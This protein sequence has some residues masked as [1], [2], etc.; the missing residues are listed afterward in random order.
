MPRRDRHT[1]WSFWLSFSSVAPQKATT[2]FGQVNRT[3]VESI[4]DVLVNF[5]TASSFSICASVQTTRGDNY[6]RRHD[7]HRHRPQS[8][9]SWIGATFHV[10]V[11][12]VPVLGT[13][14][15]FVP[16]IENSFSKSVSRFIIFV[17]RTYVP[18]TLVT[19]A[20]PQ[21]QVEPCGLASSNPSSPW[22]PPDC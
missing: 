3:L 11:S 1:A 12:C 19:V 20:Q 9:E 22:H 21:P 17:P 8:Q 16:T 6:K 14:I 13:W 2:R 7:H 10:P 15:S 18:R 5:V 4:C